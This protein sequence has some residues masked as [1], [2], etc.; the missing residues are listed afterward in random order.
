ME[1]R[2]RQSGHHEESG[3]A[4]AMGLIE[5]QVGLCQAER[6]L[7][8]VLPMSPSFLLKSISDVLAADCELLH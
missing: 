4:K 5:D 8:F 1:A 6:A 7:D 2:K 3:A